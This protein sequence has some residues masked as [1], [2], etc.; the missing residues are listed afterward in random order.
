MAPVRS[1]SSDPNKYLYQVFLDNKS[2]LRKLPRSF[3]KH[4]YERREAYLTPCFTPARVCARAADH[5]PRTE[6]GVQ[7]PHV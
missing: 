3:P 2:T 6:Y 5:L 7:P 1:M 4:Y